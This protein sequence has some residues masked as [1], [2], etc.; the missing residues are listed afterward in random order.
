MSKKKKKQARQDEAFFVEQ[1]VFGGEPPVDFTQ[2]DDVLYEDGVYDEDITVD[3]APAKDEQPAEPAAKTQYANPK[4]KNAYVRNIGGVPIISPQNPVQLSPII[5]PIA[6]VPYATQN[7]PVLQYTAEGS[8]AYSSAARA[9]SNGAPAS[10]QGAGGQDE[11]FGGDYGPDPEAQAA[12]GGAYPGDNAA[13]NPAGAEVAPAAAAPSIAAFDGP[14]K[15][16]GKSLLL[17]I[18]SLFF[19]LPIVLGYVLH[20]SYSPTGGINF[21]FG[22]IDAIGFILNNTS[23]FG[24]VFTNLANYDII[25]LTIALLADVIVFILALIG[26]ISN[27]YASAF[28]PALLAV[29]LTIAAVVFRFIHNHT[30]AQNLFKGQFFW[31]WSVVFAL[32]A[33]V[34]TVFVAVEH[35]KRKE[36]AA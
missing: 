30:F 10:Q 14:E 5:V 32:G 34:F 3:A 33:F 2:S 31:L 35:K 17:L 16:R 6:I 7:Q 12:Y 36:I 4:Y 9:A 24:A 11:Y 21:P 15:F 18:L 22:N 20:G 29:V 25:L 1:P 23:D 19:A 27:K 13:Y 26:L 28:I 8:A